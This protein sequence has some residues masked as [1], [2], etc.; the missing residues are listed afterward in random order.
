MSKNTGIIRKIDELGRVV[1]PIEIRNKFELLVG[2]SVEVYVDN[3]SIILKKHEE[4][5]CFCG[6]EKELNNYLGKMICRKCIEEIN[7]IK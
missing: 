1:I 5:S 7:K 4:S 6:K 2:D 3:N